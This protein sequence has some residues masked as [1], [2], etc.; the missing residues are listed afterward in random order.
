MSRPK[1]E[2]GEPVEMLCAHWQAGQLVTD[3]LAGIVVQSDY[4]MAAVRFDRPVFS[5]TG[6]PIPER[7]LWCTHGSRNLRRPAS[8]K[9]ES[10][11]REENSHD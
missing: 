9:T 6:L 10:A 4:R 3:W 1:F 7:V 11:E 8:A 2:F 5:S